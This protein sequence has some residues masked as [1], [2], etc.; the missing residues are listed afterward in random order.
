MTAERAAARPVE[1]RGVR[2]R[3]WLWGFAIVVATCGAYYPCL[4]GSFLWDDDAWTTRLQPLFESGTALRQIWTNPTALQ[5][6]Y[7]LT[8]TTFWADHHLWGGWTLPY[9]LQNVLLHAIAAL[10]FWKV[11]RRLEVPGAWLAAGIFAVHPVMV[12]SVA[13]VAE[14]KNVLSLALFLGALASYARFAGDW[15]AD[16][17]PGPRG[18]YFAALGLFLGALLAKVTAYVFPPTILII[19]WWKRGRISR[20]DIIPLLPFFA[21]SFVV[22]TIVTWVEIVHVGAE[23]EDWQATFGQRLLLAGRA[24]S[25][26]LARLLWPADLCFMYPRWEL[27]TG[28][29]TQ[30]LFPIGVVAFAGALWR[31]RQRLERGVFAAVFFFAG[32]IF[33]VLGFMNVYGMRFASVADHWVY[34]SSLS[35][36]ALG[37]SALVLA[38]ERLRRAWIGPAFAA[39]VLP[40][41]AGLSWRE[42]A[43]YRD[44]ET[45]WRSTISRNPGN[46]MPYYSLGLLKMEQG[47][48]EEALGYYRQ[49]IERKPRHPIAYSNIGV[50]LFQLGRDPEAV[51][52]FD[53]AIALGVRMPEVQANLA[54]ALLRLGRSDD[55]IFALRESV[56]I[57]PRRATTH[58]ALGSAYAKKGRP[59]DALASYQAAVEIDPTS[60]VA[61]F[62]LGNLLLK[63]GRAADAVAHFQTAVACDPKL[64]AAHGNLGLA[65]L[66]I[67]RAQ[68]AITHCQQAT[69]LDPQLPEAHNN[70]GQAYLRSSRFREAAAAFRRALDLNPGH[71]SA[72]ANCAWV[73]AASPDATVRDG[74]QALELA[75]RAEQGHAGRDLFTLR[76]L[77]A[78]YAETGAFSVAEDTV[79]RA[80]GTTK[81]PEQ[82]AILQEEL[83]LYRSGR[84]YRLPSSGPVN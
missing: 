80:L 82:T 57:D 42:A 61:H 3:R 7:P 39:C 37:A 67:G 72:L 20:R 28:S 55:A 81:I 60:A 27:D 62:A 38:A 58:L 52:S 59:D 31:F 47:R 45:L 76:A 19:C 50:A 17:E 14:R 70:L 15:R 69:R 30:W 71:L 41:L 1:E 36:F 66:Q 34:V 5:Q 78:A 10:L 6:F 74:E 65:L 84:P 33:P 54:N 22:G 48:A 75:K 63:H 13:W 25:M 11:L 44:A 2:W 73:L 16:A 64:A 56:S 12:E 8:G 21:L 23:G 24:V 79:Q 46:W 68:D 53:K 26:Y 9:H 4:H 35:V 32:T 29:I 51:A 18:S 77:A 43:Q 40:L 83:A 49:S